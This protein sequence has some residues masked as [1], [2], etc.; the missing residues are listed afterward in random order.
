MLWDYRVEPLRGTP[1]VLRGMLQRLGAEGWELVT[2]TMAGP[3]DGSWRSMDAL[4]VLKRP[5]APQ[6]R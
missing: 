5:Y 2:F 6:T 3:W 1:D 4:V